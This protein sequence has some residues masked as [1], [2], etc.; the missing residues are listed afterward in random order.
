MIGTD[1]VTN[2]GELTDAK[3]V[4]LAIDVTVNVPAA[5]APSAAAEHG[6]EK[7]TEKF[8]AGTPDPF[9]PGT[10][11]VTVAVWLG[12]VNVIGGCCDADVNEPV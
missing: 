2:A 8:E 5:G 11:T 6:L 10:V 4:P 12:A 7:A 1:V 3:H 9:G